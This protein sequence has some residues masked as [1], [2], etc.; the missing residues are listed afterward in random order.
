MASK[1]DYPVLSLPPL[2]WFS[3]WLSPMSKSPSFFFSIICYQWEESLSLS[4]IHIF[5]VVCNLLLYLIFWCWACPE[6][7]SG[8]SFK[9]APISWSLSLL[10]GI[11]K[12]PGLILYL[13]YSN[14]GIRHFPEESSSFKGG[15]ILE[16]KIWALDV[17]P[18]AGVS[19]FK[20][21]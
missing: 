18:A 4:R 16:T 12:Y 21:H 11:T 20:A 10:S 19:S 1:E 3:L 9:L 5:S 13:S 2:Y 17:L 6:L 7:T 14:H 8:L 15:M